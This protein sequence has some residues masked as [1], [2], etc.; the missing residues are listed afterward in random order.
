MPVLKGIVL[1]TRLDKWV[2]PRANHSVLYRVLSH[3]P[4]KT[5]I[6][7]SQCP[8]SRALCYIRDLRNESLRVQISVLYRV[9]SHKPTK[10]EI[11]A[12]HCPSSRALYYIRD[13]RNEYLRVQTIVFY[14][15]CCP[16]NQQRRRLSHH[17]ARRQGHCVTYDIRDYLIQAYIVYWNQLLWKCHGQ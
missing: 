1:H 14:T 8:S 6:V 17:N 16:I 13:Y 10:T 2:P 7:E 3:R 9:L 5:G 12:S 4:R 11:V 15:V